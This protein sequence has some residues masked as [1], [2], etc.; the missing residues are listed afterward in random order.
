MGPFS[1]CYEAVGHEYQLT[2]EGPACH[3]API[4]YF[5]M[6]KYFWMRYP[7]N[8]HTKDSLC[9]WNKEREITQGNFGKGQSCIFSCFMPSAKCS[10]SF[11]LSESLIPFI[12][13]IAWEDIQGQGGH[14][15]NHCSTDIRVLFLRIE[16]K[17]TGSFSSVQDEKE[18]KNP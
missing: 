6:Q 18:E 2:N 8:E 13:Q 14:E 9:S 17:T 1:G 7:E 11:F 16:P 4:G 5:I 12:L 10:V 3:T 15:C